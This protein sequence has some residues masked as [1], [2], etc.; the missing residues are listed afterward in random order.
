MKKYGILICAILLFCGGCRAQA[1]HSVSFQSATGGACA[2]YGAQ[3]APVMPQD[4]VWGTPQPATPTPLPTCTPMP[5]PSNLVPTA[6]PF[7]T[8][9]GGVVRGAPAVSTAPQNLT[10]SPWSEQLHRVAASATLAG[11]TWHDQTTHYL[12]LRDVWGTRTQPVQAALGSNAATAV[13]FSPSGRL[14]LAGGGAYAY[15]DDNGATWSSGAAPVGGN[16]HLVVQPDGYTRLFWVEGGTLLS[17]VQ[18]VDGSWG[19]PWPLFGGAVDYDAVRVVDGVVV[20]ASDGGQVLLWHNETLVAALPIGATSVRLTYVAGQVTLGV[21]QQQV[22]QGT[23]WLVRSLDQG[24]TWSSAC[25]VQASA[26]PVGNVVGF[27]TAQGPYAALWSWWQ[28]PPQAGHFPYIVVSQVRFEGD[29][30]A[31]VPAA[32]EADALTQAGFGPPGLFATRSRQTFFRL[33]DSGGMLVYEGWDASG[34]SDIFIAD[35][36]PQG[37]FSGGGEDGY[38]IP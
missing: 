5:T 13:G 23:A 24:Y 10:L 33:A 38:G 35:L 14:Y 36:N 28:L 15:S 12:T 32:T 17:A 30:C 37:I 31:V 22:G 7:P 2:P 20:A 6:T 9:I 3:P 34:A 21:G 1:S 4:P 18:Q 11:L 8:P 26:Q 29:T 16:P 25:L 19:W 27:P